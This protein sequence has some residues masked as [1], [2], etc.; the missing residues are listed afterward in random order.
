MSETIVKTKVKPVPMYCNQALGVTMND[1]H[2]LDCFH[3]PQL[4]TA[5]H[6]K[7]PHVI[8]NRDLY[9]RTN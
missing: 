9:Q 4:R 1:E 6:I 3:R 7:F 2:N 8:S 5:L